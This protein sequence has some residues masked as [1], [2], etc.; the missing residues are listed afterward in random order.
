MS[1]SITISLPA[2]QL[3]TLT[4][5]ANTNGTLVRLS[6]S[7]GGEPFAP[8][9]VAASTTPTFGAFAE[10]RRY[11][12]NSAIGEIAFA[13]T[14]VLG[15]IDGDLT[16]TGDSSVDG[17]TAD[18][19]TATNIG[20]VGAGTTAIEEGNGNNHTT[21]L[22]VAGVLPAITGGVSQ[23][24]GLLLYTFPAGAIVVN[25]AQLNL[26]ITQSEGNIDADTP[27]VGLGTVIGVGAVAALDTPATF[28][29][30]VIG[31]AA[32]DSNGAATVKTAI[33]TAG[34]PFVIEAAAAH[35]L[36]FN[37]ADGWAA[38]GDLAATVSGTVV[39]D[40]SFIE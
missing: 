22:T 28:E 6:N 23:A 39:I 32:A 7:A 29:D 26:A 30:I 27:E 1:K 19:T 5:D 25:H 10:S 15:T 36:H 18:S 8:I 3:L 24:V 35:T 14:P 9:V 11:K 13:I 16:V 2:E 31:T 38:G 17:D 12:I 21:T 20:A 33:P 34:E 40:W 37:A 4:A